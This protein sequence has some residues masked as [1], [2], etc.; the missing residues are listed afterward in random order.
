MLPRKKTITFV[1]SS[2]A[3]EDTTRRRRT[4]TRWACHTW[5]SAM[6]FKS[7]TRTVR[8]SNRV[9]EVVDFLSTLDQSATDLDPVSA[10]VWISCAL[11]MSPSYPDYDQHEDWSW[12]AVAIADMIDRY[13]A[14][15]G[16]RR[17]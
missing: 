15:R 14:R 13:T 10:V 9:E 11:E 17:R 4:I 12:A 2:D 1:V 16:R 6:G 7:S 8:L 3:N 5:R